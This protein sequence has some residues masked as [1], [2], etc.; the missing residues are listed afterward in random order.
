M[1]ATT[2]N[3]ETY[4]QHWLRHCGALGVD[5]HLSDSTTPFKE[6]VSALS[7][8]GARVR[9]GFYG[10]GRQIRT[11]SAVSAITAV[12]QTISLDTEVN[13]TKERGSDKFIYPLRVTFDGWRKED[14]ATEKKL[15]VE[16]DVPEY[17]ATIG[18]QAAATPLQTCVGDLVLIAFYYLLRIGEYTGKPSRNSSKQTVQFRVKDVTF[19]KRDKSGRLRQ[20][21]RHSPDHLLLA[22][23]SATLKLENQKNGW[24]NVCIHHETNGEAYL[25]PVR[26]LGRRVCHIREH[27]TK[28]NT[29]LSTY[30]VDGKAQYVNHNQISTALKLAAAALDYPSCKGIPIDR[31]DTHS[32][33]CGGANALALSGHTDRE[34]Q[35]MGRWRSATFLEYIRESLYNF[36]AGMSTKMKQKFN[37]VNVEGGVFKDVTSDAINTAYNV[38]NS[39]QQ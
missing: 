23:D 35:K 22:A 13:P 16:V 30:F 20:L 19:F 27:T 7:S 12:G 18:S 32:L 38:A 2:K 1:E 5:P 28:A 37:F 6:R 24:R 11:D 8:F 3:R 17:I 31:I 29:N 39:E 34:I 21:P 25:C 26:A 36:S 33:R 14:P 10:Q 4:W 9:R 15:P